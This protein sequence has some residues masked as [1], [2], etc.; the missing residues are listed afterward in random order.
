MEMFRPGSEC[1]FSIRDYPGVLPVRE[2]ARGLE[3]CPNKRIRILDLK[4]FIVMDESTILI[5]YA[6]ST[7]THLVKP[8]V[9]P[10]YAMH[11]TQPTK[12]KRV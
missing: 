10:R 1:Y 4:P 2:L 5:W 6:R 11:G 12:A 3:S 9:L 8:S 7:F